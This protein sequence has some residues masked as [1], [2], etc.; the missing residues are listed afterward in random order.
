MNGTTSDHGDMTEILDVEWMHKWLVVTG[1]LMGLTVLVGIIYFVI[2]YKYKEG[3]PCGGLQPAPDGKYKQE[4]VPAPGDVE[5]GQSSGLKS[6][7][8]FLNKL[9]ISRNKNGMEQDKISH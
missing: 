4:E 5:N 9:G 8:I 1:V 3:P 7:H 2:S 6:T